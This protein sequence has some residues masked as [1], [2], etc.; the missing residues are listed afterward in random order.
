MAKKYKWKLRVFC[1]MAGDPF[2]AQGRAFVGKHFS[3]MF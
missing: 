3:N 2:C 1:R